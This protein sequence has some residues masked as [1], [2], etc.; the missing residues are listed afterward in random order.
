[1]RRG[2]AAI[3]VKER[4]RKKAIE[5]APALRRIG[6]RWE[7]NRASRGKRTERP[8]FLRKGGAS[9]CPFRERRPRGKRQ[10]RNEERESQK[11]REGKPKRTED[12]KPS[13]EVESSAMKG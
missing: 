4:I 7:G 5:N 13:T 1:L 6:G 2:K 10:S 12:E 9:G 11:V 3:G 8:I